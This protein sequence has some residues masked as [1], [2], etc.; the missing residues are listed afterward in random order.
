ME[1]YHGSFI[2][3]G[4]ILHGLLLLEQSLLLLTTRGFRGRSEMK[5]LVTQPILTR[6]VDVVHEHTAPSLDLT[7]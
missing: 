1:I 6:L 3:Q 7:N 4:C 5:S 2:Q